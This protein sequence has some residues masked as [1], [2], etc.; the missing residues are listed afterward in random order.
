MNRRIWVKVLLAIMT[1]VFMASIAACKP[2]PVVVIPPD[3]G[4]EDEEVDLI[5]EVIKIIQSVNPLVSTLNG[6]EEGSTVG[7]DAKI[8]VDYNFGPGG[9]YAIGAKGNIRKSSPEVELTV[10]DNL[11]ATDPNWILLAYKEGKAYIKQPLTSVNTA[12]KTETTSA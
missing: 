12:N 4:G 5:E 8:G 2:K 11:N 1:V 9:K 7:V 6:I 10:Q 3:G